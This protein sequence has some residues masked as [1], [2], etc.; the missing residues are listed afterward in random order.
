[1]KILVIH[2]GALGDILLA[3]P[4]VG[5][6][7]RRFP[8]ASVTIAG[9][10]DFLEAVA[11]GYAERLLSVSTLPLERFFVSAPLEPEQLRFWRSFARIVCWM[12]ADDPVFAA[13]FK[14][15]NPCVLVARWRPSESEIR[16]VSRIFVDSLREWIGDVPEFEPAR[17]ALTE[18]DREPAREWLARQGWDGTARITA[19]HPGAG[20][21]AKRWPVEKFRDL[22]RRALE[23]GDG[24]A[25][26]I[27]GP[28]EP[29]L[30]AAVVAGLPP[31][32]VW[33]AECLPLRL[34]AAV[35][36]KCALFV[37]NDSGIAHLAAALGVRSVVLFGPTRPAHWAPAGSETICFT[38]ERQ[39]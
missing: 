1:V 32:R 12:G 2:P 19:L 11:A 4:A 14:A 25:L 23:S 20:S 35:L 21:A 5:L 15:A 22:A 6:L 29:G 33:R 17:V 10:L 36:S 8:E 18:A 9:N 34:L 3:L 7:R 38:A 39:K 27:S 24:A 26:V 28:A 30:G 31:D 37:G 16:H 13:N